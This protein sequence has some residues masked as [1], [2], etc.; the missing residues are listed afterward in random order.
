MY[1]YIFFLS[2]RLVNKKVGRRVKNLFLFLITETNKKKK[3]NIHIFRLQRYHFF[4][5]HFLC[6]LDTVGNTV[7][8]IK[9]VLHNYSDME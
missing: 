4:Q 5:F 7:L 1:I 2:T 6:S 8:L 3:K 9:K